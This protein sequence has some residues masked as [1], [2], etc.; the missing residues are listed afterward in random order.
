M[1][2][3]R[4][5]IIRPVFTTLFMITIVVFGVLSYQN[6]PVASIPQIEFPTIQVTTNYPGASPDQVARLV[7]SPLERQF[8]LMQGIQLVS[9][10]NTYEQSLIVLMFHLDVD[11]NVAAQQTEQ[12]IQKAMAELPKDLPQDPTYQQFNP[13]D[14]PI[15]YTVISSPTVSPWTFY[16]YGYSFLGQQLG[17]VEGIANI[18]IYGYPYAVRVQADP[19]AL[20]AKNISLQEVSDAISAGNPEKPTGKFY[21]SR[22]SIVT[23]TLGQLL[24]A[25]D[26]DDLII[27]Y[28][29]GSPVKLKD[30]AV[31][32]DSLQND[33]QQFMW[34]TKEYPDGIPCII[35]ALYRQLGHNTVT[36]CNGVESLLSRLT[37]QIPKGIIV[38][39][40]FDISNWIIEAVKDVEM[41]LA[42]A[43][44]LVVLV[45]YFYLG[46]FRS[47]MI[48]LITLPITITGTF[49]FMSFFGY[50][51]DIMSMS[52][53]T[54]AIGFLVDDAIV[55][56]ENI[57]RWGQSEKLSPFQA[58]L[59]GSK[60]IIL[61][62]ISISLCLAS[63]FLPMLF[64][65]G[66][67]GQIFHEFAGVII[68][69]V[70]ISGFVSLSLTPMLCSRFIA[71]YNKKDLTW[72]ER[73]SE[74]LNGRLLKV[75]EP[76]LSWSLKNKFLVLGSAFCSIL[77]TLFLA[78]TMPTE[79]L[80]DND[81]GIIQGF[82]QGTDGT[83]PE[84]MTEYLNEMR[85]LAYTSSAVKTVG[86]IGSNPTD[87]QSLFFIN[88]V[89]RNQ[90]KDIWS[91]MKELQE[92]FH[93]LYN[94]RI[95][96]K[97]YPLI[98]LQI[99]SSESGKANNQYLLQS[100]DS[101]SLYSSTE[102][103]LGKMQASPHL[104]NVSSDFQPNAP[105]L[106]VDL[107][108]DEASSYGTLTA[109][110]IES[111]FMYA[112]GETYISK[113]NV[114]Q[115]M[116]YVILEV[117]NRFLTDPSL[118]DTLY[119]SNHNASKNSQVAMESI[120]NATLGTTSETVNHVNALTSVTIS[121]DQADN[122]P[123]SVAIAEVES[124]AKETLPSTVM[125]Q[126]VGNSAEFQKAMKQ[127][128]GLI[129]LAIFIIYIILGIL[130]ENFLHPLTA[131]SAV[132]V[133]LLGGMLSLIICGQILSIYAIVGL[134]ML[135]GI[136]LKNG[137][138][139]IDFSL[140]IM[141]KEHI[142]AHEATY[143]A[144]LLRFRPI[145]MTTIAAMMGALPIALGIGGTV[146]NGRSPLGIAVVGGLIFA[147]AVTL[148]LTPVV[149]VYIHHLNAYLIKKFNIQ[150]EK[151][152]LP[153]EGA[154][155]PRKP[156]SP[157]KKTD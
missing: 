14:T 98:N 35:L 128:A 137:I 108:R 78:L 132:P 104:K 145:V 113:I 144:C 22:T 135:L 105:V 88:L 134:L 3:S 15:V 140:E 7:S 82:A 112:Y 73:F 99:G 153:I 155:K 43:F 32:S 77:L 30:V 121:F 5:F 29:D 117:Q 16:E 118:L 146:A 120:T 125:G 72:M 150:E 52:A 91:V 75:Y 41:T 62:I 55:V 92:K 95:F 57:V 58:A 64:M 68:I 51:L 49:L 80:P 53:L 123:L 9:S 71:A 148:F 109:Q 19:E 107:L 18:Q 31:V 116:Y 65:E 28:V 154:H 1:N 59:F 33:K 48:P 17:T 47:S 46:R 66:S 85:K 67:T 151:E 44:L 115:D 87:S 54:L 34:A 122:T 149:F 12:A 101:N 129:F 96:L 119:L 69:A 81:L 100:F 4:P 139:I 111:A 60:Q 13:S 38:D 20:A 90:R 86:T 50:S 94:F 152:L 124:F 131:L 21:G 138:L 157:R 93:T 10:S 136:V 39:V 103:L 70:L 25:K 8:M 74:R 102:E 127:F 26:Y 63:V 130:Y 23:N 143:K 45:V 56:L 83:S 141:E 6:L 106:N 24:E 89:D 114:P 36:V 11:I 76:L 142:P 42:V 61:V 133:A 126:V 2:I 37:P 79:F 147:Q 97:A 110:D 27:K 84:K 156:R 40:P